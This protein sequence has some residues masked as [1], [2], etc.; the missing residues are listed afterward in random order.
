MAHLISISYSLPAIADTVQELCPLLGKY[1]VFVFSG[2]MGAGKT[3]F[4]RALCQY[5]G[6]GDTV[7]S[8][9]FAIINEYHINDKQ[10]D[11]P[12]IIYHMDWYRIKNTEEAIDAGV[13]D[14]LLQE[15]AICLVEWPEKAAA[16]LPQQYVQ[17]TITAPTDD[18]RQITVTI[19]E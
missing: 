3:T 4:I 14:C 17:L 18:T 11:T 2:E 5:L 9:T 15:K 10:K 12:G 8:P 6:V 13:E 16:L 7:N 19:I 1:R